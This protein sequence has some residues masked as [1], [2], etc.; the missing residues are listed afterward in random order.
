MSD[1]RTR[2][3]SRSR[4]RDGNDRN[5]RHQN[6]AEVETEEDLNKKLFIG[7]LGY[8]VSKLINVL[9]YLKF[10]GTNIVLFKMVLDERK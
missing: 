5:D 9:K 4:D 6:A 7:N 10:H 3:R 2:D 1:N 8:S